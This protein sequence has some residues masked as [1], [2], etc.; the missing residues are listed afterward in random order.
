MPK[1]KLLY[2]AEKNGKVFIKGVSIYRSTG[3]NTEL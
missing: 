1:V 2:T 3:Q